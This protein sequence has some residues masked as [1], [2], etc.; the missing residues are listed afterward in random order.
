MSRDHSVYGPSQWEIVLDCN[1][2]FHWL[3]SSHKGANNAESIAMSWQGDVLEGDTSQPLHE[4]HKLSTNWP[5]D[6]LFNSLWRLAS[7]LC[8]TGPLSGE[9]T[10][11]DWW[12]P[13]TKGQWC[14]KNV[15]MWL[16]L[17]VAKSTSCLYVQG[18]SGHRRD[19]MCSE[20]VRV[21]L[22]LINLVEG[23]WCHFPDL[24]P[25]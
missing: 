4:L 9:S 15:S 8:I 5:F 6:C 10:S 1:A 13:L 25:R 17:R 20:K 21:S 19:L 16:R 24:I 14:G 11:H 2:V 22:R 7:K 18:L 3:D 23:K 12:I